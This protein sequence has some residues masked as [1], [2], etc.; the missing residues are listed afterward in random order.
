MASR[1]ILEELV[2]LLQGKIQFHQKYSIG[3]DILFHLQEIEKF[4]GEQKIN[5]QAEMV[6][7][8]M[9][10][11]EDDAKF[12]LKSLP[13]FRAHAEDY[14][15]IKERLLSLY[16]KK[17][18]KVTPIVNILNIKQQSMTLREY[19]STVRIAGFIQMP[20]IDDMERERMLISIFLK[21]VNNRQAA[22]ATKLYN[23]KTLEETFNFLK[24]EDVTPDVERL[25]IVECEKEI[26]KQ[27]EIDHL[28]R[29]ISNLESRIREMEKKQ[30]NQSNRN[31]ARY[32]HNNDACFNCN[33]TGH[34]ARDCKNQLKCNNCNKT[35]HIARFCRT[36]KKETFRRVRDE[37]DNKEIEFDEMINE[38]D[39]RSTA[40]NITSDSNNNLFK[41]NDKTLS[42]VKTNHKDRPNKTYS[43][44][45]IQLDEYIQGKRNKFPGYKGCK[46]LISESRS[47]PALNKPIVNG[48]IEDRN[49]KIFLDTGAESSVVDFNLFQSIR[50]ENG[51]KLFQSNKSLQCANGSKMKVIGCSFIN[52]KLG[53]IKKRLKFIVVDNLFPKVLIGIRDMKTLDVSVVPRNDCIMINNTRIPFISRVSVEAEN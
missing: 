19:L 30:S 36:P 51:L 31:G 27:Q 11:L 9:N 22:I 42:K 2:I 5:L 48:T 7:Q 20:D 13:E 32:K 53:D 44:E 52:I 34:L 28:K 23:P 38:Y 45:I 33:Q 16:K 21:G 25:R 14:Q 15:W 50:K 37:I 17:K 46:T 43:R 26:D 6:K 1:T 12:E 3:K 18:T 4:F 29:R 47:E 41:I 24:K 8:L 35:G 40:S 49:E 39:N 10:S